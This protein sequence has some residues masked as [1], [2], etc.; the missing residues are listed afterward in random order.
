MGRRT[1]TR[2]TCAMALATLNDPLSEKELAKDAIEPKKERMICFMPVPTFIWLV[3]FCGTGVGLGMCWEFLELHAG[4]AK[5]QTFLTCFIGYWAQVIVGGSYA[6]YSAGG[7]FGGGTW[8]RR[9]IFMLF[10][11]ALFDG[12]AQSLNYVGQYE[13]G[14]MLFTIFHASVTFWTACIATVVLRIKLTMIQWGGVLLIVGGLFATAIPQHI[15]A[16]HSYFWGVT[17]SATGSFC[18][19]ASYPFSELVFKNKHDPDEVP[20]TEESA[21]C[22]GSF[23][24]AVVFTV[25]T[26]AYTVP[27]WDDL[28]VDPGWSSG[29]GGESWSPHPDETLAYVGYSLYGVMVAMHSLSFWKSVHQLGTVPTAVSKGAQQ[30]GVFIFS[31]IIYCHYDK[32]E[33]IDNNYG[34]SV[35]HHMQKSVA[36]VLCTIGVAIY[37]LNKY[38][39]VKREEEEEE[40]G[41]ATGLKYDQFSDEEQPNHASVH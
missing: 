25:Y 7:I 22:L 24:N 15:E 16:Q 10:I 2:C 30:A 1:V 6:L 36:F 4:P 29:P 34:T 32:A 37:S 40:A 28:V 5:P 39:N 33:C 3:I 19:A 11:S 13:G 31:H 9:T 12:A 27:K 26:L 17:A 14:Q 23:I 35:W 18:L 41:R 8:S 38:Q 20:P 21:C